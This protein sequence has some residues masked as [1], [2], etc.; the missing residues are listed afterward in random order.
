MNNMK[1]EALERELVGAEELASTTGLVRE[2]LDSALVEVE[3]EL[4]AQL[5]L[6]KEAEAALEV[7]NSNGI[8]DAIAAANMEYGVAET[9]Y[10]FIEARVRRLGAAV[11]KAVAEHQAAEKAARKAT[12]ALWGLEL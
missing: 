10:Y 3:K 7:A 1:R 11:E 6:V 12:L 9:E 5:D 2:V 8:R 4:R